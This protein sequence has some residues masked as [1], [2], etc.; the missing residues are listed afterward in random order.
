[1]PALHPP[2]TLATVADVYAKVPDVRPDYRQLFLNLIGSACFRHCAAA[3]RTPR[4]QRHVDCFVDVRGRLPMAMSSVTPTRASAGWPRMRGR[5]PLRER[6]RW[7]LRRTARRIQLFLQPLVLTAEPF[8]FAAQRLIL[9]TQVLRRLRLL[10]EPR[11][12]GAFRHAPR[13]A[14][15]ARSVQ[16]ALL[17]DSFLW[18]ASE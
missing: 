7:P 14:R 18:G 10:L 5:H 3:F 9:A 2:P 1:M 17:T 15:I 8:H 12:V 16:E 13:Y 4:R 6:R 11:L